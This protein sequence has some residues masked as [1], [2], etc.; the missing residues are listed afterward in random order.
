MQL[1]KGLGYTIVDKNTMEKTKDRA[2]RTPHKRDVNSGASEWSIGACVTIKNHDHHLI[3]KSCWW[4]P[5][6]VNK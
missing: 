4:T 2:T 5:V 1:P 6:Y 3:W